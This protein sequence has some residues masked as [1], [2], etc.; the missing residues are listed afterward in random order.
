[1]ED[2]AQMEDR[3]PQ[4]YLDKW[5]VK[6]GNLI[7]VMPA[8]GKRKRQGLRKNNPKPFFIATATN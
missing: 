4:N 3:V 1:M 6:A 5:L 2:F 7:R 8:K